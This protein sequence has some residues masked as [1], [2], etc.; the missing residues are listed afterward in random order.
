ML[1]TPPLAYGR[2]RESCFH[3][4]RNQLL[5]QVFPSLSIGLKLGLYVV[6]C[7]TRRFKAAFCLFVFKEIR[8]QLV[9]PYCILETFGVLRNFLSWV[10]SMR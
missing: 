4:G 5:R 3:A 2:S 8:K 10:S 6:R 9:N 7:T 1:H